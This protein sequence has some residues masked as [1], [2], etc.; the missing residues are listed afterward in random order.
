MKL[1]SWWKIIRQMLI[2]TPMALVVDDNNG[3][4]NAKDVK[5]TSFSIIPLIY[6][7]FIIFGNYFPSD[8]SVLVYNIN[9]H[10]SHVE[11]LI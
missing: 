3:H 10:F 2:P 4:S 8:Q 1:R 5:G 11:V 9:H 7:A 6:I